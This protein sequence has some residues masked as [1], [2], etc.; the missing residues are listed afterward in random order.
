MAATLYHWTDHWT[1]GASAMRQITTESGREYQGP[2]GASPTRER[3]AETAKTSGVVAKA[4][5]LL[6]C[7]YAHGE[8]T[9]AA[10][11][12][13][14]DEPRTTIY[15]LVKSLHNV[16]MVDRGQA[17]ATYRLGLTLFRLG[18]AAVSRLDVR[19]AAL[20]FM[21]DLHART[22]ETLFLCVR[23]DD[24]AVC[25]ERI[26]GRW[27]QSGFLQL[28][29]TMP[30]HVGAAPRLLL[31]CADPDSWRDYYDRTAQSDSRWPLPE[32]DAFEETLRNAR[33]GGMEISDG[34][35]IPG[36][37]AIGV[38]ILDRNG[39]TCASLSISGP[40]PSILGDTRDQ[41]SGQLRTASRDI[42]RRMGF[43]ERPR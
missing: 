37:A 35:V 23:R 34:D 36:I 14:L 10:L 3:I 17:R 33:D 22:E 25:I 1:D 38:P 7:L 4:S 39:N 21:R 27:V 40:R 42:S 28:G 8:L 31:A 9:A 19:E 16:G 32:F 30:L 13:H 6:E 43:T 2:D 24:D 11:A 15:R 12:W 18:E 20:P 29:G 26:D 5:A 41:L